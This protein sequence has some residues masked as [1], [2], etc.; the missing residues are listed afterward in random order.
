MVT[1]MSTLG[2]S[3][4]SERFT[5][6]VGSV[7]I[8][9]PPA[10]YVTFGNGGPRSLPVPLGNVLGGGCSS[11]HDDG[12]YPAVDDGCMGRCSRKR[13]VSIIWIGNSST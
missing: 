11:G 10:S 12:L 1:F 9:G 8:A 2:A 13:G 6:T 5:T 4:S 7:V 3:S